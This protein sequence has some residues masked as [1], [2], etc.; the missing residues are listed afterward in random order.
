VSRVPDRARRA[1][2]TE[3]GQVGG[4]EALAF[5][6]LI[7]VLGTLVVANAWGVLDAKMA[8]GGAAR[9]AARAFVTSP[10]T[11][12]P[13]ARAHDAAASSIQ[14]VG[15][16]P[17]R[18]TLSIAGAFVRCARIVATVRYRVPLVHIPLLGGFGDGLTVAARHSELVD[19]YRNG[20]PGEA[21]CAA[22]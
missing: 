7:F 5:G 19:P 16:S 20:L 2:R 14:A 21:S 13:A 8:A 6:V 15:R 9:E 4:I 3:E 22:P 11:A 17:Q 1:L 18:M 10:S 12:D